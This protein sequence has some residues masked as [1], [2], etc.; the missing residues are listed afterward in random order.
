MACRIS[1]SLS[2]DPSTVPL[3]HQSTYLF[4]DQWK[5]L[6]PERFSY[7]CNEL[8][9]LEQD[10]CERRP[11]AGYSKSHPTRSQA[12]QNWKR[13][14]R[15]MCGLW[16]DENDVGRLFQHPTRNTKGGRSSRP[17]PPS[18]PI[19]RLLLIR[20]RGIAQIRLHGLETLR[21]ER[22]CFG[23]VHSRSD[24]AILPIFPVSRRRD[25]ELRGQLE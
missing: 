25:L 18:M 13:T 1:V 20:L 16:S 10:I 24:D 22:L 9:E 8:I 19:N 4:T 14:L 2:I 6:K 15:G 7:L 11:P 3:S 17:L 5:G 21:K 12:S 23:V